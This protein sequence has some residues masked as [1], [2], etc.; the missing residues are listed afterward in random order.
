MKQNKDQESL[1]SSQF[2]T[3]EKIS[4]LTNFTVFLRQKKELVEKKERIS[5]ISFT[6]KEGKVYGFLKI[7]MKLCSFDLSPRL[8]VSSCIQELL[9]V[10]S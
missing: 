7:N 10:L 2:F 1:P 3:Y 9:K 4:R 5:P 6:F 8:Y